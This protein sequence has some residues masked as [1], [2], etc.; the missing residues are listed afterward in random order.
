MEFKEDNVGNILGI[1]VNVFSLISDG[2]QI[3][4]SIKY[5]KTD[6]ISIIHL[7]CEI[8]IGITFLLYGLHLKLLM[9]I[10]LNC[11]YLL[12]VSI[13][14]YYWIYNYCNKITVEETYS[15]L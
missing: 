3:Y 8:I 7:I 11:S 1:I 2:S 12:C 9:I 6:G 15:I 5:Q 13:M 14:L 10:T 4:H